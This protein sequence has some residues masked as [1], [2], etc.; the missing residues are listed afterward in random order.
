MST[1]ATR[2]TS[3]PRE[4]EARVAVLGPEVAVVGVGRRAVLR[5]LAGGARAAA[6]D[7]G[8]QA[9]ELVVE[10]LRAQD[11]PRGVV[12]EGE[13]VEDR[14]DAGE[15]AVGVVVGGPLPEVVEPARE[16]RDVGADELEHGLALLQRL[17]RVREGGARDPLDRGQLAC[18]VEQV[19]VGAGPRDEPAQVLDRRGG[20]GH[21]R[22][23]GARGG[24]VPWG[25][26]GAGGGPSAG[27]TGGSRFVAGLDSLTR[28]SRSSSVARRF[29]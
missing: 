27:G 26:G 25:A 20:A 18:R 19:V 3:R 9:R 2:F 23:E 6:S 4:R 5:A 16:L 13:R 17:R 22:G 29:T 1:V 24:P 11:A 21:G 14:L 10:A 12:R 15:M 28:G 7:V 8:L